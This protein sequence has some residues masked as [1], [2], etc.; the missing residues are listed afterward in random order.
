VGFIQ[1]NIKNAIF[2]T[3]FSGVRGAV[4]D[5]DEKGNHKR[6]INRNCEDTLLADR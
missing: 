1:N 6:E 3:A 5:I 4:D 2:P